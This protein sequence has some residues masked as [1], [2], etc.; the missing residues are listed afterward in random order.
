MLEF[1]ED[2]E[3]TTLKTILFFMVLFTIGGALLIA[4]TIHL[5]ITSR[6]LEMGIMKLVGASEKRITTPFVLEGLLMALLAFLVHLLLVFLSPLFHIPNSTFSQNALMFEFAA[7]VFLG[8]AVSH[9]TARFHL[10]K[11]FV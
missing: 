2:I 1:I 10:R 7:T 8:V 11:K 4:S 6:R 9:M 5:A 3:K